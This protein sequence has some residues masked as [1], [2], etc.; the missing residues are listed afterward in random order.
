MPY[1]ADRWRDR[2]MRLKQL[3][4]LHLLLACLLFMLAY[5]CCWLYC[6]RHMPSTDTIKEVVHT[7]SN[8]KYLPEDTQYGG[9]LWEPYVPAFAAKGPK[10]ASADG[11]QSHGAQ[12]R[13]QMRTR[14]PSS[15]VKSDTISS[16]SR[17]YAAIINPQVRYVLCR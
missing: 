8:V 1:N 15:A 17:R 6:G 16:Q 14:T 13:A 3:T 4:D 10:H 2:Q 12:G 5:S 9:R 7:T 11:R